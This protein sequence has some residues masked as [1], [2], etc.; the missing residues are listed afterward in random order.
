MSTSAPNVLFWLTIGSVALRALGT[1]P[2][3]FELADVSTRI[4]DA[5][6]TAV[7]LTFRMGQADYGWPNGP[8]HPCDQFGAVGP[9]GTVRGVGQNSTSGWLIGIVGTSG[10]RITFEFWDGAS[11]S[12]KYFSY[13]FIM[14]DDASISTFSNPLVLQLMTVHDPC[15]LNCAYYSLLGFS[16]PVPA[17][18]RCVEYNGMCKLESTDDVRECFGDNEL[19]TPCYRPYPPPPPGLPPGATPPPSLPPSPSPSP[20]PHPPPP[21]PPLSPP[22]SPEYPPANPANSPQ[23][24]PPPPSH[25]PPDFLPPSAPAPDHPHPPPPP[26]PPPTPSPP[27]GLP[28]SSP[29]GG[30]TIPDAAL[31]SLGIVSSVTLILAFCYFVSRGNNGAAMFNALSVSQGDDYKAQ[32]TPVVSRQDIRMD[33]GSTTD[34]D[35]L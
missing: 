26:P 5:S 10:E 25:P 8:Y 13:T 15:S 21:P 33:S 16:F 3:Q 11:E 34:D 14:Q 9:D 22:P 31:W 12:M 19:T 17:D 35:A 27:Y 2:A 29:D 7:G 6:A 24:P 30:M 1:C 28:P 32:S 18:R 23:N 4:H 20:S